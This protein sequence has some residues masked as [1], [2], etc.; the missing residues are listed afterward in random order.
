LD[1]STTTTTEPRSELPFLAG[2]N[3]AGE[4]IFESVWVETLV[5]APDH[6]RLLKSP[7]FA[8]NLAAGDRLKVINPVTAEYELLQRSG[9]LSVRVFRKH[10]LQPLADFLI[11]LMEKAG[12][13]LDLQNNRA[14]VF[15]IHV[16]I[17]FQTIEIL[18]NKSCATYPD[19]IWYYGNV[20]DPEDGTTPLGWWSEFG[21]QE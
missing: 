6:V 19:T 3:E 17:G 15:S 10:Q 21:S 7:L 11:P 18:L 2:V 5:S 14:L 8:R 16:S 20:Y 9:N 13:V 4:A 12:G 1:E